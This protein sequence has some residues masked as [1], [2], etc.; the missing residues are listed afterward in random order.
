MIGYIF[1]KCDKQNKKK[2]HLPEETVNVVI[3][4][5]NLQAF[6]VIYRSAYKLPGQ[7]YYFIRNI[8]YKKLIFFK[9]YQ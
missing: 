2:M 5:L 8:S 9:G 1:I 4:N 3:C 6:N 7:N